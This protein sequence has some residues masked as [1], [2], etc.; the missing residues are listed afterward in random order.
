MS[1]FRTPRDRSYDAA[2]G[3]VRDDAES[4]VDSIVNTRVGAKEKGRPKQSVAL[5]RNSA[6][7]NA[8]KKVLLLGTAAPL[9]RF[10]IRAGRPRIVADPR[11]TQPFRPDAPARW[12][13]SFVTLRPEFPPVPIGLSPASTRLDAHSRASPPDAFTRLFASVLRRRHHSTRLRF[14]VL[15]PAT[16]SPHRINRSASGTT[17]D[18]PVSSSTDCTSGPAGLASTHAHRV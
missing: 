11:L 7:I 6:R 12:L 18:E 9:Q 17:G 4:P 1:T 8:V 16:A 10:S 15:S 14:G 2:K 13:I 5:E 3:R